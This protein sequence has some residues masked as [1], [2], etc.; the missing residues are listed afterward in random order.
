MHGPI[1]SRHHSGSFSSISISRSWRPNDRRHG[2]ISAAALTQLLDSSLSST[3]SNASI[4]NSVSSSAYRSPSIV[5]GRLS[6]GSIC[7]SALMCAAMLRF[8]PSFHTGLILPYEP[9]FVAGRS[10]AAA[11]DTLVSARRVGAFR[12]DG[13]CWSGCGGQPV[14]GTPGASAKHPLRGW[15]QRLSRRADPPADV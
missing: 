4:I 2:T 11:G 13:A 7:R 10:S 3:S 5:T 14:D 1:H 12:A 6:P 9:P 15:N 8:L